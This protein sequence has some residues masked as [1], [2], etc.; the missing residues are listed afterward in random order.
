MPYIVD[1]VKAYATV[2]EICDAM[3]DIFGE[4]Q[5]GGRPRILGHRA[6]TSRMPLTVAFGRGTPID[7]T[8]KFI[9]ETVNM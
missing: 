9:E 7:E 2:G 6:S 8:I 5:G 3:R 1:A 4:Y